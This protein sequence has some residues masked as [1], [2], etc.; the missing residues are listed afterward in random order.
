MAI[1]YSNINFMVHINKCNNMTSEHKYA[2]F[3]K[4]LITYQRLVGLT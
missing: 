3:L 2:L 1:L 4:A